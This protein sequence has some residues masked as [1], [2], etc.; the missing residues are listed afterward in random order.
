MGSI[1]TLEFLDLSHNNVSGSIMKSL[2]KL[3][4]LKDFMF[5]HAALVLQSID[6][7]EKSL[8]RLR[9]YMEKV[10]KMQR[11]NPQQALDSFS[12][13]SMREK[14]PYYDLLQATDSLK[15][16]NL[17]GS[18]SFDSV[19]KGILRDGTLI[20]AKVFNLQLQAGFRS[21]DIECATFA[22]GISP[23]HH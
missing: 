21:F 6:P 17:I 4:N 22:I 10:Y 13:V 20:A 9:A 19:Y 2:E 18:G 23:I 5:C 15:E 12:V 14:T 11:T 7:R 1:S 3:L 8:H 16:S